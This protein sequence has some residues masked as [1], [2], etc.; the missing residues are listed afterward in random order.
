MGLVGNKQQVLHWQCP[1]QKAGG[2]QIDWPANSWYTKDCDPKRV[3]QKLTRNMAT[4]AMQDEDVTED[5]I[6]QLPTAIS[7]QS[8]C[9]SVGCERLGSNRWSVFLECDMKQEVPDQELWHCEACVEA[10]HTDYISMKTTGQAIP[11]WMLEHQSCI[12]PE[13]WQT[14]TQAGHNEPP[15]TEDIQVWYD[16]VTEHIRR[17]VKFVGALSDRIPKSRH[18]WWI[19][20]LKVIQETLEG[21]LN[22]CL[23]L[24][25]AHECL[26]TD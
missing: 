13:R 15:C 11:L 3:C 10:A 18:Q 2:H 22:G 8:V 6:T 21:W 14:G 9:A 4:F 12:F 5:Y 1:V 7:T 26:A 20:Q 19:Q 17:R 23:R 25:F 16:L 24:Q